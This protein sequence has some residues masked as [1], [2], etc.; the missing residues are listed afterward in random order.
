VLIVAVSGEMLSWKTTSLALVGTAVAVNV[1][2]V[3]VAV[4][5]TNSFH[6]RTT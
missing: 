1:A 5:V 3:I 4:D 2:D 6:A